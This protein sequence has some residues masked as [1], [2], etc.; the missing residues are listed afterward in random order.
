MF[1]GVGLFV[2]WCVVCCLLCCLVLFGV[3]F[4]ALLLNERLSAN[5]YAA[6]AIILIALALSRRGQSS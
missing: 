5:A 2:V 4:G 1:L 3:L 6:L